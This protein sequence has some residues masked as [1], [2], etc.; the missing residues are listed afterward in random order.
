MRVWL[1]WVLAAMLALIGCHGAPKGGHEVTVAAAA[2]LRAVLPELARAYE[3]EH[4]GTRVIA[5]YGA[6]GDLK[7]Q[8]EG[9]APIDLV[10]FAS[11]VP[12]DALV[13]AGRA[14]GASR[15]IVATNELVL[16]TKAGA[17]P[18]PAL[19]FA[20]LGSLPPTEMVAVGDPGA[21][22]A[23]QYAR[24]YLLRLGQWDAL[25]GRLVLGGDVSAV[26]A[27]V[28]RGEV[29][30]GVVYRTEVRGIS[31][32]AVVDTATGPAAPRP[33]VVAAL[34]VK[35]REREAAAG[36]LAFVAS[37]AGRQILASYGFSPP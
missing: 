27:Y 4:R 30:A 18:D 23:G 8:V 34:V 26:L 3:A 31:D 35:A 12:V 20:R 6:S 36:F 24:D 25:K 13:A 32:A 21:V 15:E 14:E 16:I 2:S 9:G 19:A 10:V 33:A 1:S 37:P 5:S 7:K 17:P 11:A 28:R 22:P 29:R